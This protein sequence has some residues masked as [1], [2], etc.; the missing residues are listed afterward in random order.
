M[1]PIC[2][3]DQIYA[4]YICQNCGKIYFKDEPN[5]NY[6]CKNKTCVGVRLFRKEKEDIQEI[7]AKK[8][9]VLREFQKI[10]KKFSILDNE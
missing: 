10:S 8:R 5:E 3:R 1:C 6:Y 2:E 7:L 9:V 4:A